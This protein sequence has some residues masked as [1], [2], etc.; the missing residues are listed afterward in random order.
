MVGISIIVCSRRKLLFNKLADNI[1]DTIGFQYEILKIDNTQNKNSIF[2]AYNQGI[3]TASF[4]YL[5]FLHEDVLF[6]TKNWGQILATFFESNI[7]FDLIGVAGS[8]IKSRTPSGWWEC[9]TDAKLTNVI[10]HFEDGSKKLEHLGFNKDPI[11][12]VVQVD[13]VFMALRKSSG[14]RFNEEDFQGFHGYD[15]NLSLEVIKKGGKIGVTD[16]ILI[17]HFS[18]GTV[19]S[20]WLN[21]MIKVHR[22]YRNILPISLTDGDMFKEELR[23]NVKLLENCKRLGEKKWYYYYKLRLTILKTVEKMKKIFFF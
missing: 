1:K 19:D 14:V 13:G 7:A 22:K 5:L 15:L 17:E 8:K 18:I 10:Q 6:R 16:K 12:E 21:S 2:K 23:A 11:G 4:P 3:A 20:L 9:A